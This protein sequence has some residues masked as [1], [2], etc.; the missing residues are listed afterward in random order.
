MMNYEKAA[1]TSRLTYYEPPARMA[2][3]GD[4]RLSS[5]TCSDSGHSW[6]NWR[7][8]KLNSE[9]KIGQAQNHP[10]CWGHRR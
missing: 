9:A 5:L 2:E 8:T 10:N 4:F 6:L 1:L 3:G 7:E